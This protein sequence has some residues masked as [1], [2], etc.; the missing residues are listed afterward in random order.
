MRMNILT[1]KKTTRDQ[2][3]MSK[4]TAKKMAMML[5]VINT[6]KTLK[7]VIQNSSLSALMWGDFVT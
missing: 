3:R 7:I 4:L 1:V 5:V 6:I 2:M